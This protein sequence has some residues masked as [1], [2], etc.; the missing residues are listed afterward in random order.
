MTA[1]VADSPDASA[2]ATLR[3]ALGEVNAA[4]ARLPAAVQEATTV[5][6]RGLDSELEA[7]LRSGDRERAMAAIRA[8]SQ[9]W[10]A[11]FARTAT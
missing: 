10:L 4:F 5:D 8:W 1:T 11:E 2:I 3:V 7:S 6:C 9:H